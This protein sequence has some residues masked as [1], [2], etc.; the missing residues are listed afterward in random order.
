VAYDPWV[1]ELGIG[2]DV[3][4]LLI[5]ENL[6]PS[7]ADTPKFRPAMEAYRAAC[8]SLMRRLI[9]ILAVAMGEKETYFDKKITYPIAGIRCLYYPPQTGSEEEETGLGAHTDVQSE[10]SR[11]VQAVQVSAHPLV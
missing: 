6:W 5:R 1:D 2:D 3:P 9:K 11:P 4:K 8:L 10:Y 7:P